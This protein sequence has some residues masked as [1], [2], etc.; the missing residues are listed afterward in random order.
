MD[1]EAEEQLARKL[2]NDCWDLIEKPSRTSLED[3][4]MLHLA[5]ASRMHW[6]NVGGQVEKS[7][8]EWQCSRVNSILGNGPAALLHAQLSR[9][10]IN[11][12]AKPHFMYASSAEALAYAN[13][14]L[15]NLDAANEFKNEA[16]S[17][18]E[19][20][21]SEDAQLIRG[22]IEDLPF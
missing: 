5:N 4:E 12:I 15:G 17:Y 16:I 9:E 14:V 13:F 11:E 1:V 18:L 7:I 10:L 20:L 6:E 21:D 3:A 19:A 8:G 22:Q 2:Y